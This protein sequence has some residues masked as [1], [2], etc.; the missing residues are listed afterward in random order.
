[1]EKWSKEEEQGLINYAFGDDSET[2]L[3]QIEHAHYMLYKEGNHPELKER[4]LSYCINKFY[5]LVKKR[6]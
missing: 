4:S 2:I 3:D 6:K 5:K 1:M